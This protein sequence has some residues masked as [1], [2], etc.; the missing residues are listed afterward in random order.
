MYLIMFTFY[1]HQ[2]H[3]HSNDIYASHNYF[4]R[5][6][7]DIWYMNVPWI[8]WATVDSCALSNSLGDFDS[9][10]FYLSVC[11]CLIITA[12]TCCARCTTS[13]LAQ[14]VHLRHCTSSQTHPTRSIPYLDCPCRGILFVY[15]KW[16]P[17]ITS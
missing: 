16:G 10:K 4:E 15:K 9:S 3:Y 2:K 17:R 6:I 8:G 11:V 14:R 13:L 5:A 7:Y 12:H 1:Y